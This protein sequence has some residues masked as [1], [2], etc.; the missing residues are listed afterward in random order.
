MNITVT[1]TGAGDMPDGSTIAIA[2]VTHWQLEVPVDIEEI[3]CDAAGCQGC[4]AVHRR[5]AG[6]AHLKLSATGPE[7]ARWDIP[8]AVEAVA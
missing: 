5:F 8:Q 6:T 7:R 1:F 2:N 4:R 3:G